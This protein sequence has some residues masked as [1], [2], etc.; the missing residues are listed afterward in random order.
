M[1]RQSVTSTFAD[2]LRRS[3]AQFL[4]S[5]RP[6]L[7]PGLVE[8]FPASTGF[9][10]E[11]RLNRRVIH[12]FFPQLYP[13]VTH[14]AGPAYSWHLGVNSPQPT[15]KDEGQK[16]ERPSAVTEGLSC[17]PISS[18]REEQLRT[19]RNTP[20]KGKGWPRARLSIGESAACVIALCA[21]VNTFVGFMR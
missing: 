15:R 6:G 9:S 19:Y 14:R 4:C 2:E 17:N 1:F 8:N 16:S 11:F 5:P 12:Q 18:G 7:S 21:V 3:S 13:L 20:R 10:P